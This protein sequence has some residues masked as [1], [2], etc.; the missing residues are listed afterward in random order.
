MY[1]QSVARFG[2]VAVDRGAIPDT[3]IRQ[4]IKKSYDLVV[5]GLPARV[6]KELTP[7]KDA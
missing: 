6:R 7:Q 5:A 4:L 2:W 1:S 3:Q